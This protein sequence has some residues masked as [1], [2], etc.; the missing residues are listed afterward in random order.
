MKVRRGKSQIRK[1]TDADLIAIRNWLVDQNAKN[2]PGSFLC[3]WE[4]IQEGH[5]KGKLLVYIDDESNQA[6]AFR[7]GGLLAPGILEVRY[8]MRGK[9]IG[10]E[11]VRYLIARHRRRN[12]YILVVQ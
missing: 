5:K 4:L 6:I 9:G 11:L 1:S 7:L 12:E 2:I 10:C 8:D 3:N